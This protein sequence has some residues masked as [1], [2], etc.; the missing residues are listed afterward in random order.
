MRIIVSSQKKHAYY[1]ENTGTEYI[2][3]S[4]VAII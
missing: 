3:K 2:I 4:T 1:S